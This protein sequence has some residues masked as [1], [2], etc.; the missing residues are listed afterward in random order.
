MTASL[1]ALLVRAL[2]YAGLFPPAR[3]ALSQAIDEHRRNRRRPMS[4]ILGR[5]VVPAVQL[6]DLAPTYE[7]E[8]DGPLTVIV[9]G[10]DDRAAFL[11]N[12]EQALTLVEKFAVAG[13]I[14][15]LE[16]RWPAALLWDC[17]VLRF[18]DIVHSAARQV[19]KSRVSPVT[20]FFELPRHES[21]PAA[22]EQELMRAAIAALVEYNGSADAIHCRA[23]FKLRCGGTDPAGIPSSAEVAAVICECRNRG[24]FW[25]AT[26]GLHHPLRQVDS[27]GGTLTHGF[28]NLFAAAVLADVHGLDQR[29]T[30]TIID[31]TDHRQLDF[32]DEA[33]AWREY[34][35]TTEQI[36]AA[37]ERSLRSFG[38]CSFDEPCQDLSEMGML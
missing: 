4:W 12:V 31:E 34:V 23:G 26:A 35:V 22:A 1:R 27:A 19:V 11:M 25:K 3:M 21:V 14:D 32:S 10:A 2:D 33:L 36:S 30:L 24:V 28:L 16:L 6:A 18:G 37:R 38:S 17:D 8:R 20:M 7:R 15:M 13:A 5:F 29:R 9:P